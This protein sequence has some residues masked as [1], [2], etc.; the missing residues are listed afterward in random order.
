MNSRQGRIKALRQFHRLANF[1]LSLELIASLI[2]IA[3]VKDRIG[4]FE[5]AATF[6]MSHGL[7]DVT[8]LGDFLFILSHLK[9]S[10]QDHATLPDLDA[11]IGN[12]I[13]AMMCLAKVC[14]IAQNFLAQR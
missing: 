14:H 7:S 6:L 1:Q 5:E 9:D 13:R 10:T 8:F 4:H 3:S 12:S 2:E 11:M